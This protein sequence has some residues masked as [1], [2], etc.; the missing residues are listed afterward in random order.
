MVI[1][2]SGVLLKASSCSRECTCMRSRVDIHWPYLY[3]LRVI[4]LLR[5]HTPGS[6]GLPEGE[7]RGRLPAEQ[8]GPHVLRRAAGRA[9]CKYIAVAVL[10]VVVYLVRSR[11]SDGLQVPDI[12][13]PPHGCRGPALAKT[14]DP[15][16]CSELKTRR[17][18]AIL[19]SPWELPGVG[20]CSVGYA[21]YVAIL[22]RW[23]L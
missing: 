18:G 3:S 12:E 1:A 7:G 16:R 2:L 13:S 15:W 9:S 20:I 6:G 5:C 10:I 8:R 23:T 22:F 17:L 11:Y 14:V 21:R 19:D 4:D